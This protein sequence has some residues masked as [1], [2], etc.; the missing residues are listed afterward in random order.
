MGPDRQPD[1]ATGAPVDVEDASIVDEGGQ[2]DP[3]LVQAPQQPPPPPLAPGRT[4]P[5]R[6]SRLEEDV[7]KICGALTE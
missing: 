4:M 1:A 3:A 6:M 2:A 7:H 5:Q